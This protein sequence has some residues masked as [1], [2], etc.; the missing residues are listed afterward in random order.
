MH[1]AI[2]QEIAR[3]RMQDVQR[4]AARERKA[5][6]RTFRHRPGSRVHGLWVG[7][8]PGTLESKTA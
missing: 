1:P 4:A 7:L 6:G 5:S 8:R 2:L 3:C